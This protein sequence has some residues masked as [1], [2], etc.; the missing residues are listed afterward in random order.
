[1]LLRLPRLLSSPSAHALAGRDRRRRVLSAPWLVFASA[2]LGAIVFATLCPIGW[3]PRLFA[4]PD[5]ERFAAFAA[6]GFAA[7]LALPRKDYLTLPALVAL[8]I[9]LEA[10]Q[11]L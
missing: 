11:R 4:N 7:K 10:A 2:V 1:M 3:R 5:L 6:L 9:G 8:A